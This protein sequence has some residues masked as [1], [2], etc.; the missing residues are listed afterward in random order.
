MSDYEM[1]GFEGHWMVVSDDHPPRVATGYEVQMS[2][3]LDRK[4]RLIVALEQL[5]PVWTSN[6]VDGQRAHAALAQL[7]GILGADNQTQACI[8]A[9]E[10]T[11]RKP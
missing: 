7:W 8:N 2:E 3:A 10:L 6:E 5:R 4:D 9:R 1:K 11:G